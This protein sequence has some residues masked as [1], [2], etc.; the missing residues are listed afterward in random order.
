M[1]I[2]SFK[3]VTPSL[4]WTN[5]QTFEEITK[6][7]PE[8]SLLARLQRTGGR[9]N[10]GRIS[11]RHVGGG[12]KR[13]YRIVDFKRDKRDIHARVAANEYAPNRN[14]RIALLFYKD[15]DKR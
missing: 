8:K 10:Q 11:T 7:K 9:N 1:G 4:R 2:K 3:P 5:T 15:G 6:T 13:M 12:H 14:C